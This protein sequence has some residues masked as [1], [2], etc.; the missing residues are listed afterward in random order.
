MNT[1]SVSIAHAVFGLI[2]LGVT[3]LWV[4]GA[5]TDVEAPALAIW[6]PIVL[7]GAGLVGLAGTIFN[8]RNAR[9]AAAVGH[10]E[11]ETGQ[12]EYADTAVLDHEEPS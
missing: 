10:L 8:S 11:P 7:I 2:F 4:V 6:G 3:A 9:N 1:R 5:T 12:T